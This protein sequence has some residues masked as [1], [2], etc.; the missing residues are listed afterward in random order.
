MLNAIPETPARREV[1]TV[2]YNLLFGA[3]LLQRANQLRSQGFPLADSAT[4][5]A[6]LELSRI[7]EYLR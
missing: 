1:V 5:A 3:A 7:K 2:A 4:L 6:P